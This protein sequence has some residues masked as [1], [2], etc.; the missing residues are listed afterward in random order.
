MKAFNLDLIRYSVGSERD[1]YNGESFKLEV[2]IQFQL[3]SAAN[4]PGGTLVIEQ[5]IVEDARGQMGRHELV[6][7]SM[8]T[9]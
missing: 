1:L 9:H 6:K 3:L 8:S 5:A 7:K 4:T 2:D